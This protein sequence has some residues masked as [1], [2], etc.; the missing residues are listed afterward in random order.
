MRHP[1]KLSNILALIDKTIKADPTRREEC[2]RK[3]LKTVTPYGL[4]MDY[5]IWVNL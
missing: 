5:F 3:V 4:N 2:W 1:A